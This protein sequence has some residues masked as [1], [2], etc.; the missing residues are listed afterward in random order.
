MRPGY[1]SAQIALSSPETRYAKSGDTSI[2]YQVVGDGPIDL[3]HVLGFTSHLELWWESPAL[4]ASTSGS[5]RS[6]G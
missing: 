1:D 4:A 3:V 2:A 6:R 5:P